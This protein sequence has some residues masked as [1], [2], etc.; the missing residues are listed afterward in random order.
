MVNNEA[1]LTYILQEKIANM[2]E[3]IRKEKELIKK[4]N[5]YLSPSDVTKN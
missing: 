2:K 1:D 4:I 3:N 5:G